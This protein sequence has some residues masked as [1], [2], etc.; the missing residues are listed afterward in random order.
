MCQ[1]DHNGDGCVSADEWLA[2]TLDWAAA[3][4][5]SSWEGWVR[6]VFERFDEDGSGRISSAELLALL[7]KHGPGFKSELDEEG[8]YMIPDTV[9]SM[10]RH[11]DTDGDGSMSL[12]EFSSLLQTDAADQLE[13]FC[14][15]R[16]YNS[17]HTQ[18]AS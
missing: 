1:L 2:L 13:L 15:R 11:V 8:S 12:A 6:Q 4:T 10:M 9:P 7:G 5:S 14:S 3:Q 16:T 18:P 17:R